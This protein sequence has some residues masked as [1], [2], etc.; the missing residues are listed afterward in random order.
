MTHKTKG[1]VLRTVKYGETSLVV[2]VLTELF[3]IQTYMVNGV[4]SSKKSSA[5]A[6][7]FQPGAILDLVVY[8][9]EQKNMQRIKE[10]G[11]ATVYQNVLTDVI[12]NSIALYMVELLYKCLKQPD[13]N[14]EL[15]YFVE[16]VLLHLDTSDRSVT[17]NIPLYFALHLPHFLGF[18]M[19]DDYDETQNI[20]DLQEGSF[21]S[22]QPS[23]AHFIE[24]ENAALTSQI[25]KVMQPEELTHFNL[26]HDTRRKLL[27]LYHDYYALHIHDFGQMKTLAVLQDVL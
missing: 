2:T 24:G 14:E 17:A 13:K 25:L 16:D 5:K 10:F 3:G 18:R 20:L 11:W 1:I 7:L 22:E 6:N 23:H 19:N 9:Y 26:H 27:H 12:K 21:V 8:H 15:F 4:R